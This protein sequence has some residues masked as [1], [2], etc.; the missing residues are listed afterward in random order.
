MSLK[1]ES[2]GDTSKFKTR[3]GALMINKGYKNSND[4][5]RALYEQSLVSVRSKK[6]ELTLDEE[7]KKNAIGSIV[8]KVRKHMVADSASEIQGEFIVAYCKLFDCSADYLLGYSNAISR[9]I[10]VQSVCKA[11]GLSEITVQK[12]MDP[13]I[14]PGLSEM[15]SYMLEGSAWPEMFSAYWQQLL[16]AAIN[17]SYSLGHLEAIDKVLEEHKGE[18]SFTLMNIQIKRKSIEKLNTRN[19]DKYDSK[20]FALSTCVRRSFED[21]FIRKINE[22]DWHQKAYDEAYKMYKTQALINEDTE[23]DFEFN[24]HDLNDIIQRKGKHSQE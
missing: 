21:A 3:L 16:S 23:K 14:Q 18:E 9:D 2:N 5:A 24:D 8:K 13:I 17:Q 19:S 20:M 7:L 6:T 12:L 1:P 11:T 4:L 15:L 10:T 22:V